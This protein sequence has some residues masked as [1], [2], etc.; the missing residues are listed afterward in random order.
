MDEDYLKKLVIARLRTIPPNIS[1][2]VG[3]FGDYTRDQIINHVKQGTEVGKEFISIELKTLKMSP[4]I[5]R[6][7]SGKK[8]PPD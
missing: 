5:V 3:S 7:L 6:L 2:S 1:F 8:N 4:K